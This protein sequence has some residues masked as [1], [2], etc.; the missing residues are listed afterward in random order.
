MWYSQQVLSHQSEMTSAISTTTWCPGTG[1]QKAL[2]LLGSLEMPHGEMLGRL[3]LVQILA[4]HV[5]MGGRGRGLGAEVAPSGQWGER[6]P[7]VLLFTE[8]ARTGRARDAAVFQNRALL[9]H[10][11]FLCFT[12]LAQRTHLPR[13]RRT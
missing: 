2:L 13:P 10:R 4:Q 3:H 1:W 8:V 6:E 7:R 5:V 12:V 9:P 11:P